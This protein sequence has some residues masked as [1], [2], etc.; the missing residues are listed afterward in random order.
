MVEKLKI[1]IGEWCSCDTMFEDVYSFHVGPNLYC[2]ICK[3]SG[4][5]NDHYHCGYCLK[6]SQVG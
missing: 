1:D 5:D 4:C 6:L 3:S 2:G